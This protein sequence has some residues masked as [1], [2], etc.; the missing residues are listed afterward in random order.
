MSGHAK[1]RDWSIKVAPVIHGDLFRACVVVTGSH[2]EGEPQGFVFNDLGDCATRDAAYNR[3]IAWAKRWVDENFRRRKPLP[4]KIQHREWPIT[5]A[6]QRRGHLW[7]AWVE[8]ERGP[9]EDEG[10]GEIFH[11]TDIG[12]Y[13]TQKPAKQRGLEWAKAWLDSNY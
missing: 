2:A 5:S 11:F 13:D 7:Q 4:M 12:Y 10:Q 1:Y 9:W 6:P 3:G 8:V